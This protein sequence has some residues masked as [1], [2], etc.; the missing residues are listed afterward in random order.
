MKSLQYFDVGI[1]CCTPEGDAVVQMGFRIVL[2][3]SNLFSSYFFPMIQYMR[4]S[5]NPKCFFWQICV[6]ALLACSRDGCLG[7]WQF[8]SVGYVVHLM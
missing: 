1:T 4:W 8:L 6:F 7:N 3:I 5:C 2:C